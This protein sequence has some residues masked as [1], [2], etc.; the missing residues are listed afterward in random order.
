MGH[1][2][3]WD[4]SGSSQNLDPTAREAVAWFAAI[5]ADHVAEQTRSEFR[6]W[7][8]RDTR[9]QAAYA[10]IERIWSGVSELPGV[11][12][13]RRAAHREMTRRTLGKAAIAAAIGGAGWFTYQQYFQG[14][15]RTGTGERRS[16]QLPDN[17]NV[18]MAGATSFSLDFGPRLRLVSLHKG[19]AFFSSEPDAERP[20]VV[21]AGAGRTMGS[22]S[23]FNVDYVS[24]DDV[25]VTVL[26]STADVRIG[27][28]DVRVEANRQVSY[29]RKEIAAPKAIDPI[30]T[31]AW[32]DG[33]LVFVSVPFGR[34]VASINRWRRGNLVIV[35]PSLADRPVTLIVEMESM[36][37]VS[38]ILKDSLPVRLVD[39]TPYLTL[40][41][42]A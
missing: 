11:K 29:S 14:D 4:E 26:K 7:L 38:D 42:A 32:R 8:R 30:D 2:P 39:V 1:L 20:F 13:H 21:Q 22:D 40:I 17:S 25:R 34:V 3:E 16:V 36:R 23:S 18:E 5:H 19:E 33:R 6:A 9:H 15:Y 24:D 31:L 35:N 12:A 41:F 28:R 37:D 10:D 27:I